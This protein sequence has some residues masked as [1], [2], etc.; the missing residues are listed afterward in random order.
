MSSFAENVFPLGNEANITAPN[1]IKIC[2]NYSLMTALELMSELFVFA[3]KSNLDKDL[4]KKVLNQIYGHPAFKRYIDK[5]GDRQFDEVNFTMKGGQ[6]DARI[7]QRA[8]AEAG[9]TLELSNL[10]TSRFDS[11]L[12]FGM[13]EKDW[14]GIYE[15]VRKQSGLE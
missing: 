14:S 11:A 6:K 3:E 1:L 13:Q 2:L 12:S 5:I 15:V 9:V 10:L 7:F 8:F 4:V